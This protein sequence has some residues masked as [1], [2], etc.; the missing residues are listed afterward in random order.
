MQCFRGEI[1]GTTVLCLHS[2]GF[3]L[4]EVS[5]SGGSTVIIIIS[6]HKST[7][8]HKLCDLHVS[9]KGPFSHMQQ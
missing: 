6:D 4:Q 9:H 8:C 7:N 2:G 5:V 3:C 1:A